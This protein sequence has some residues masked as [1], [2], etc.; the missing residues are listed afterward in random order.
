MAETSK[1]GLV[2]CLG[3][4][5][6]GVDRPGHVLEQ[7]PHFDR[8]R[9]F[10]NQFRNMR[11]DRLNTQHAMIVGTGDHPNKPAVIASLTAVNA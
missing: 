10:A 7:R 6:V 11:P 3:Q 8:Q 5:R 2:E 9:E 4:D 1:A